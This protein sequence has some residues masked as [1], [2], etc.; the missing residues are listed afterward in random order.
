MINT[1]RDQMTL[2]IVGIGHSMGATAILELARIHPRLFSSVVL[3]DPV[4]GLCPSVMNAGVT[5]VYSSSKRKDLWHSREE[6]ESAFK[7]AD[8][9]QNWDPR[10]MRIWLAFGLRDTP[11]RLHPDPGKVTL[12]TSK[13]TEAWNYARSWFDPLPNDGAR[14]TQRSKRAMA[15]YPDGT[16]YIRV[17]HPFYLTQAVQAW[18]DLPRLRSSV[19]YIFPD[20]GPLS[21]PDAR[22]KKLAR[23]G[24]GPGGSGGEKSGMAQMVIVKK[25]SH[26]LPFEKPAKCASVIVRWLVDDIEAWRERRTSERENRDDKS[27]DKVALSDEWIRRARLWYE[28][29]MGQVKAKL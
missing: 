17:T 18:D 24:S 29:H 6:A 8:S 28:K 15:K 21:T 14:F 11:T 19:L 23:T 16:D 9:L 13:A 20:S 10:V 5:L 3:M 4:L 25:T 27:V 22:A 1:F 2:P 26:L 12:T 7:S